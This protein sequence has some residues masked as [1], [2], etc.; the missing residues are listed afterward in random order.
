MTHRWCPICKIQDVYIPSSSIYVWG[1]S[2]SNLK[3]QCL[4]ALRL[5][6][7]LI[8]KLTIIS[9]KVFPFHVP[10]IEPHSYAQFPQKWPLHRKLNSTFLLQNPSS[11]LSL[12]FDTFIVRLRNYPISGLSFTTTSHSLSPQYLL[13]RSL[14]VSLDRP[15]TNTHFTSHRHRR[16]KGV[17]CSELD[18]ELCGPVNL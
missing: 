6:I 3:S 1:D 8:I 15:D 14:C 16:W 5:I 10:L 12:R 18:R 4:S 11:P 9:F 13:L 7:S 2:T 17:F